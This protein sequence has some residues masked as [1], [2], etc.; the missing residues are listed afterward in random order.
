[1][2]VFFDDY[3]DDNLSQ[4]KKSELTKHHQSVCELKASTRVESY[5]KGG[6]NL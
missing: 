2:E 6:C 3:A 4:H 1:V 5:E